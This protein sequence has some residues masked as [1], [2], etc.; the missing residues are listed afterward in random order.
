MIRRPPRSTLFPYTTLFR[1]LRQDEVAPISGLIPVEV[2]AVAGENFFTHEGIQLWHDVALYEV[3]ADVQ[4][5]LESV[6]RDVVY[7]LRSV[8]GPHSGCCQRFA[9]IEVFGGS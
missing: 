4:R 6:I 8:S 7:R 5:Y 2:Q 1:S 9:H 3:L